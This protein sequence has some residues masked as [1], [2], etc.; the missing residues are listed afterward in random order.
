[1][2]LFFFLSG[3]LLFILQD[4]IQESQPLKVLPNTRGYMTLRHV[5]LSF[6]G[7][8]GSSL[9]RGLFFGCSKQ[10]CPSSHGAQAPHCGGFSCCQAWALGH[11]GFRSCSSQALELRLSSCDTRAQLLCGMWGPPGPGIEPML[12]RWQ[13]DSLPLSHLGSPA[14]YLNICTNLFCNCYHIY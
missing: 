3:E 9:L 2:P 10:G 12:L 7:C 4:P 11:T 5:S 8:A 1:M 14:L 13:A 6:N